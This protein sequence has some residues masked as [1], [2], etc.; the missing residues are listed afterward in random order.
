MHKFI[1]SIVILLSFNLT[2][3]QELSEIEIK[4]TRSIQEKLISNPEKA[5]SEALE[6]SN[7]KNNL[8]RLFGKYY[9]ANY[10]YNK[11]DFNRSK[12]LLVTLINTIEKDENIKSS[13]VYQ[14]LLGMCVNKLF[15]IHKNLGEYDLALLNLDKHKKNIPN[16][17]FYEQY[18]LIKVAMG[19]YVNGIALLKKELQTSPHLKLGVGEKK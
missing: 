3:A 6:I 1:Y 19:D 18:G 4:K 9:V 5:Y 2:L 13:K 8:F 14:D 12:K 7:S 15:Y 10:F 11:S 17:H 16:N